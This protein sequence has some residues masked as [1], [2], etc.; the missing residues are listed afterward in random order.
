MRHPD[1]MTSNYGWALWHL[2]QAEVGPTPDVAQI[3]AT[4]A[5]ARATLAAIDE[6]QGRFEG[7]TWNGRSIDELRASLTSDPTPTP[8]PP[9]EAMT[10][11]TEAMG[12]GQ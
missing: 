8:T 2:A 9:G 7:S 5:Q 10:G 6:R 12:A 4:A 1:D 11:R 3:H